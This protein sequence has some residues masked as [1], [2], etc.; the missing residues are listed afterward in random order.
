MFDLSAVQAAIRAQGFDGWLLYDFRGLNVLA[1]RVVGLADKKLSRRWFYFVPAT[2]DPRKLV[3]AI[4]PAALD[5]L[6]GSDK[7]VFRRWQELEAGVGKLLSGARRV[8]MEYSPKNGNPYVS[9]VDAGTVEL[10][11]S[12]GVEVV[13]SGDL[14]SEFEA[15]WDDEQE[16]SHFAAA[17]VTDA[18]YGVAWG[19]IAEK[20]KAGGT[21]ELDVQKRIMDHFA[22][23]GC[24]TYSPP[25]VGV[26][27]HG[28]DPHYEPT[29]ATNSPIKPGDCVLID[30]WCK[31]D[32]PRAVYS[33][34]TRVGYIGKDV[35]AKYQKVFEIVAAARDAGIDCVQKAFAAGRPLTGAEVDNATRA[36]IEKAGYGEYFTHRTGHNIGQEVHGNGAHIDGFETRDD[37][38]IGRRTCFSI[39]PGIYLPE[40]GVRL[41]VDVYIDAKGQVHVTGG[42]LQREIVRVI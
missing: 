38:K 42:E 21:T 28:G 9:R 27:P 20:L 18:A 37:R 4:E 31:L 5:S 10:V 12:F 36:V 30:L 17:K 33:D 25:I 26:G 7:T 22:Q 13:S 29:P 40:F 15:T 41:E 34:L 6:P 24:T 16:A 2:G 39:E 14:I 35:P 8:A 32:K 3:H 11:R 23:H 1:Q 19:F